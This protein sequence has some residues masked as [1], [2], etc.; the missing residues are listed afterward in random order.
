MT[1]KKYLISMS[2]LSLLL[3]VVFVFIALA[4]DPNTTNW[5]GLALFYASLFLSLSGSFAILGFLFRSIFFKK[6]L[7]F[8]LVKTAFRQSFLFSFLLVSVLLMLAEN[9]FSWLNIMILIIILSI[10]EYIFIS[11]K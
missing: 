1:L 11:E 10:V 4:V 5:V 7:S 8:Y 3:W 2:F 6:S 9:L